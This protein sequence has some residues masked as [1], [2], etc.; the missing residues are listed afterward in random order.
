MQKGG[1]PEGYP[2]PWPKPWGNWPF[3]T[4]RETARRCLAVLPRD[5]RIMPGLLREEKY[6]LPLG[7]M[8][9]RYRQGPDW[10]ITSDNRM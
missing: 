6:S 9:L 5:G 7:S 2:C 4:L 3:G 1:A 10:F 8:L